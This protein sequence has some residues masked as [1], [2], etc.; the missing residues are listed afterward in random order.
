MNLLHHPTSAVAEERQRLRLDVGGAVQGVGFR[1]FVHR[2]AREEGL[3]GFV[4]NTGAGVTLEVE[5]PAPAIERFLD[6]LD[7]DITAPAAIHRRALRRLAPR[8]ER[9]F[10][11]AASASDGEC[12]AVILPDL[13]T[14]AACLAE[15][16]DPDD[17]RYRYPFTTC[18]HCG[19]RYSI[20]EA[21]PYDR[22]RT[23]MRRFAMCPAC[24]AEYD[25]PASRRFHA[26]TN[27]CPDC[28]P[29]LAWWDRHGAVVAM[30]DR[31]LLQAVDALRRG[32]IVAFKGLGGF[33]LLVDA[34][35]D[36]AVCRLRERKRRPAKPF[37]LMV[38]TLADAQAIAQ[39][40]AE[41]ARLLG[42]AAAPI[43]L[44]RARPTASAIAPAVA[45]GNPQWGVMLPYTPLHHLLLHELDFPLVATSGNRGEEPI[46][47]DETQALARLDGLADGFLVHDRPI[48]HRVDDSVVRLIAGQPSVLRRARGHAPLALDDPASTTPL[49]ALGGH[50]KTAVAVAVQ[51]RI[52]LGPHIGD[53]GGAETRE[54][55]GQ[56]VDDLLGLYRVQ[57]QAVACDR[58]PDYHSTRL[59]DRLGPAVRRVPHHLAHVLAGML[60]NGLDGAVLGVAWDGNGY[61]DD[62]TLWGGEFLRVDGAQHRRVASL[63]P[64]CLPGG[65]AAMREP[66]RA[67]LGVLHALFGAP[68][69][70][71]TA[72]APVAAFA[73]TE[74]PLLARML[75]RKVNAPST[76]SAGRLFDAVAS[77]LDLCQQAS[78]EGEAAMAVEF[79]AA[80]AERAATVALPRLVENDG[81]L[82][83]DWRPTLTDL[84]AA[85]GEG[86]SVEALAAAFHE[87]LAEAIVAV[88]TRIGCDQVLL[89]GGCFQNARLTELAVSR[90]READLSPYWHHRIPPNDGGLAAGQAVAAARFPQEE[91]R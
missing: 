14:C 90:L 6:R 29:R 5:G 39:V 79:A 16:L 81:M 38:R 76:S 33:Q 44:L 68:A 74:R 3:G 71:M 18:T 67:A 84:V 45:P 75:A 36:D 46:V 9:E 20:I 23:T 82:L 70:A 49:L 21:V 80:R 77:I 4:R 30:A 59:A 78:F 62:G 12:S 73:P 31:A 34:R 17:R 55:Y 89:T 88:A 50:Q 91:N 48:R 61:G 15:I 57:A 69:M 42:S 56:S 32:E 86:V 28:G 25:D 26:E 63:W 40:D 43:V 85:R 58:H 7:R 52:V 54:A 24:Q 51:G 11:I 53:L 35:N 60:D 65:E 47:V 2:L 72:L 19:P 13:A 83:V 8:D 41:E 37:A 66:R 1:P 22:D 10:V 87:A 27:A 64:F